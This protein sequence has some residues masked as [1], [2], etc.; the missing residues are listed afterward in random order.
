MLRWPKLLTLT[1]CFASLGAEAAPPAPE[2][3]TGA[4]AGIVKHSTL[5]TYDVGQ[6]FN[7][8]A[9]HVS[10]YLDFDNNLAY[11]TEVEQAVENGEESS[12]SL[13][14][15]DGLPLSMTVSATVPYA[16]SGNFEVR[17]PETGVVDTVEGRLIP[18]NG[19]TTFFVEVLGGTPLTGICQKI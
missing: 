2:L 5:I 6:S 18:V 15:A 10:F 7:G 3:P 19:G 14:I 13:V 16:I 1:I 9:S 11:A 8:S 12:R 17:N 4:C